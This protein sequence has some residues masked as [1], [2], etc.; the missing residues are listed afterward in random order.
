MRRPSLLIVVT[1]A[2]VG[3][4]RQND[5]PDRVAKTEVSSEPQVKSNESI[6]PSLA[7]QEP[8]AALATA[9]HAEES[10]PDNG[11]ADA[12]SESAATSPDDRPSEG[13]ADETADTL[14]TATAED[15]AEGEEVS[16]TEGAVSLL[17]D[18]E[19][20]E[21]E[22]V[23]TRPPPHYLIWLPTTKGPIL[24]GMDIWIGES[25]LAEAFESTFAEVLADAQNEFTESL[26]WDDFIDHVSGNA[27]KFGSNV[28]R[29]SGQKRNLIKN[30]DRNDNKLV[31]LEEAKR[32]VLRDSMFSG[33]LRVYG[34]DAFRYR[35]RAKSRLFEAMD[36]DGNRE[37]DRSEI[38]VACDSILA[39]LD[40]NSD[41]CI[42]FAEAEPASEMRS[43]AWNRRSRRHGDVAMDLAGFVNWDNVAYSFNGWL[44]ESP[45]RC[46]GSPIKRLDQDSSESIEPDEA[47]GLLESDPSVRLI[48]RYPEVSGTATIE[49]EVVG[50]DTG[51]DVVVSESLDQIDLSAEDFQLSVSLCE[52]AR[53]NTEIPRE[54]FDQLD[55]NKDGGLDEKEI[56]DGA[57]EQLSLEMYD[58][59]EDGK[60]S[61]DELTKRR[62]ELES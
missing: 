8:S 25:T 32:F 5:S 16:E 6:V 54:A 45:F 50:E 52:T 46:D 55:A 1:F 9:T 38:S 27:T 26:S 21:S 28:G 18:D 44:E 30:Y 22:F 58:E 49:T 24:L 53:V 48:V 20:S 33:E 36:R 13:E 42:A 60:L 4:G 34:T 14:K 19:A 56:P 41:G 43:R 40:A 23:D 35:N 37:L 11:L 7:E 29:L 12:G 59:N 61:Y 57:E 15:S 2:L 31:E 62:V 39:A 47:Q 3:C 17:D 51:I 10:L